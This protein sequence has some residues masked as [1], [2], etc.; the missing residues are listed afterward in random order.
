M[1]QRRENQ[2]HNSTAN[3]ERA[4]GAI[5]NFY[6]QKWERVLGI[7]ELVDFIKQMRGVLRGLRKLYPK[8]PM[9]RIPLLA[10]DMRAT[11]GGMDLTALKDQTY[12]TL[13][14]SK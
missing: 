5:R 11:R 10:E 2:T 3:A 12:W 7:G 13:Y 6:T 9:L 4:V 8:E 14:S 1:Y